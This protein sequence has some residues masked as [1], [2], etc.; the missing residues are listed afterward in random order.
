V[1]SIQN[2]SGRA[3]DPQWPY[4]NWYPVAPST[5]DP[6]A[7]NGVCVLVG[8]TPATAL[9]Y[10]WDGSTQSPPVLRQVSVPTPVIPTTIAKTINTTPVTAAA[11]TT[12]FQQMQ[13]TTATIP[14]LPLTVMFRAFGTYTILAS[15]PTLLQV[16]VN[17]SLGPYIGVTCNTFV[18]ATS[19]PTTT[20][21]DINGMMV[22]AASGLSVASATLAA[23]SAPTQLAGV[24]VTGTSGSGPIPPTTA[25]LTTNISFNGQPAS[26]PY[27]SGTSTYL[28]GWVL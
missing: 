14:A 12:G 5:A 10:R 22:F 23:T 15:S 19:G 6:S 4:V 2:F 1:G 27:N 7:Q 3:T 8:T 13:S 9:L 18:S 17:V 28:V 20:S 25:A 11:N 21:W 24:F 26:S 16:Q